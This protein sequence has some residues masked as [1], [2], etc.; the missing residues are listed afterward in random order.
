M[1]APAAAKPV[2]LP[3][4]GTA[5]V[6]NVMSGDTVILWGKSSVP[7]QPPPQVQFTLEGLMAPRLAS[8]NYPNDDPGAFPSREFLRQML[9]GKMVTFETT[10][11]KP[12]GGGGVVAATAGSDAA[13]QNYYHYGHIIFE[14]ENVAVRILKNGHAK[15]RDDFSPPSSTDSSGDNGDSN[16][17]NSDMSEQEVAYRKKFAEAQQ[18]AISAKVGIHATGPLVRKPRNV[19]D[20]QSMVKKLKSVTAVVEYIFD[21]S[22]FR[23]Q[24]TQANDKEYI[25]STFT[26]ILGGVVCPR[27]QRPTHT[28]G[29]PPPQIAPNATPE[30]ELQMGARARLFVEERLLQREL[31]M[32]LHGTDKSGGAAVATIQ[33]PKGNIA[34]E[35]LKNGMGRI[36]DWSVRLMD[37][38][39]VPP[40]RIAENN[41]KRGNLGV[42]AHWEAPKL[43]GAAEIVGTCVEVISGDTLT[44]LPQGVLYD[45][46]QVLQKISLASIRSPRLGS[47]RAGRADEPYAVECKERLR[48]LCAGKQV[49]VL[50]HYE[51]DIPLA[52]EVT[53]KRRFGTVSVGKR[54][55]VGETLIQE[56]LASTQRHRDDDEKS[57]RYDELRAAEAVAKAA[58]KGI[59]VEGKE[60]KKNAIN[61]LTDPKKAKAYAESLMR[62][63][64]LKVV[65]EF[66]FNGA[67]FKVFVPSENCYI[68]FAPN[69]VRCP[70]P[71]PSAAG[72][73]QGKKAEPFGDAAKRHAR[74]SV[75]QRTVEISCTG[76]TNGGIITG[77]LYVGQ[78]PQ[79]R[80]YSL[81][82]VAAGLASVDQ[83]KIDYGEAPKYLVDAHNKAKNGKLGVWSIEQAAPTEK[84]PT[85]KSKVKS[86]K[87]SLSEI[88]S[89]SH[90]FYTVVDDDSSKAMEESMKTF[91]EANGTD[92]APCEVKVNRVVAAL[93]D[94]GNG[95]SWYRAKVA[96]RPADGKVAVLFIDHGNVATVPVAT[97]LR[98]LDDA[99]QSDKIPAVAKEAVLALVT[100]RSLQTDE[101]HDAATM[102][103][104]LAWGKELTCTMYG[105]D[106]DNKMAVTLADASGGETINEQ[107]VA[108]GLARV[109]SRFAVTGL[110]RRM[111]DGGPAIELSST[112]NKAQGI[113]RKTRSGMWRY[114]DIGDED[115]TDF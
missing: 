12:Q 87:I 91:T 45:S 24:I 102:L 49:K 2:L 100:T 65:V 114:G 61:D 9:I 90:F 86:V 16:G 32:V 67:R 23:C 58:K 28:T 27:S 11:R 22:R 60:Y 55:D 6:K 79:R 26:L 41:A 57:P 108:A 62:G 52:P 5:R 4:K 50:V 64:T 39:V 63:G 72:A 42:W 20:A 14:N 92:G 98:P 33:H 70:Q 111:S 84:A 29:N 112:L 56:G 71:S 10:R 35:L 94:D 17:K 37:P 109:A 51:R 25:H 15:V 38:G 93:F 19:E 73:K 81:E 40:L 105:P 115:P 8:K 13:P 95:K 36:A 107:L 7:N 96:E 30:Q 78:G 46:E 77:V 110:A 80:D 47:E 103:Q 53:E 99:L 1:S 88:R 34:V 101:G 18:E 83:R 75:L 59:H 85:E 44:I 68:M 82:L 3:Q 54:S 89:G 69:S 97:H 104:S 66:V 21:G 48:V 31:T 76:V 113:A 74:L 106:D 43:S